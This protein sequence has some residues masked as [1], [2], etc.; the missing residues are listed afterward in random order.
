M[1][2]YADR[3][4]FHL[5]LGEKKRIAIATVLAMEPRI[6]VLDEPTSGLDPRARR[7]LIQLLDGF[8]STLLICTHDMRLV[9][10]LAERTAIMDGGQIVADGPTAEVLADPQLLERHGLEAP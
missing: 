8:D 6:L 5:S 4:P 1:S 9:A 2:S 3:V 10:E 7:A